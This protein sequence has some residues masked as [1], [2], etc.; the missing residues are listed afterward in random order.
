VLAAT[1]LHFSELGSELELL[2][3]GRNA[4]LM[5]DQVDA[6]WTQVCPALDLLASYVPPS[7]TH[8]SPND[9]GEE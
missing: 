4:N 2:G 8:S 6:P 1:L 5:E 9:A 3:F 7:A